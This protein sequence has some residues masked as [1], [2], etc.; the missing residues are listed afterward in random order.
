MNPFILLDTK[1]G[2]K[3]VCHITFNPDLVA[4]VQRYIRE[5][6]P[7]YSLSAYDEQFL[8]LAVGR[9]RKISARRK[10]LN[11]SKYTPIGHSIICA[12]SLVTNGWKMFLR[13]LSN[14][15]T[16]VKGIPETFSFKFERQIIQTT[17]RLN[18]QEGQPPQIGINQMLNHG[19]RV[20]VRTYT[21]LGGPL[22]NAGVAKWQHQNNM[23]ILSGVKV[24]PPRY[25]PAKKANDTS[26]K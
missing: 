12:N 13:E 19:E 21:K 20:A 7:E 26:G 5:Y 24:P 10:E 9:G 6:R 23:N 11:L 14:T 8:F 1:D 4:K 2:V 3:K 17:T 16:S 15:G 22:V 25:E 18:P